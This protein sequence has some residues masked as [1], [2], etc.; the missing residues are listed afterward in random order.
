MTNYIV[1]VR[2]SQKTK[3]AIFQAQESNEEIRR[4]LWHARTVQLGQ[5]E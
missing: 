4:R 1:H 3:I 2:S 5:I